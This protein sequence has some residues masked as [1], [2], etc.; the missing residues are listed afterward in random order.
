MQ[1]RIKVSV[2]E[3]SVLSHLTTVNEGMNFWDG[4]LLPS[5]AEM[6][7]TPAIF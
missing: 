3:P 1:T 5:E 6:L 2:M 4:V 7:P